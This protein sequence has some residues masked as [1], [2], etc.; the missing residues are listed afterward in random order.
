LAGGVSRGR[1]EVDAVFFEEL[2]DIED[3]IADG[4]SADL[5]QL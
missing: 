3:G 2:A 5:A 1:R 4:A